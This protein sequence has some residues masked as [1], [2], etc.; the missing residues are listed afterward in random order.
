MS[1]R[2]EADGS[3]L[4]GLLHRRVKVGKL[5]VLQQAQDLYILTPAM[6]GH[7]ALH[8]TAQRGELFGQV[9]ALERRCLIQRIDLPLDQRQVVHRIEDDVFPFPAPRMAGD[10]LAAAADHHLVDITPHPDVLMAVGH[11]D[12]IVVGFVPHERLGRDLNAGLIAGIEWRCR[13]RTHGSQIPLQPIADRLAFAPQSVTLALA[14]LFFKPGVERLPCR[15]LRDRNHEVAP[16]I[17]DE[18]LNVSLVISLSRTAVAIPDEIMGQEAAEQCCPLACPI[19]QDFCDK[20]TIDVIN[21]RLRHGPEERECVDVAVNPGLGHRRRISPHVAAVAMRQVEHEEM[22]LLL[23]AANDHHRLAEIGLP[24]ARWM[25]QWHKHLLAT[26]IPLAH[27]VLEDRIAAGEPAF[28]TKPVEHPLGRM[29]LLARH[30][31]VLI[32]PVIDRRNQRI[33]LGPPDR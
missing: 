13:Q 31:H 19:G 27:I 11:R 16:G 20:A 29:A 5:K 9:P 2:I 1:D 32:K 23:H 25:S 24:M 17:T 10:D 28:V 15:E 21:Y 30:L 4:E 26:L 22:S 12:G 8:Q 14:A 33:Q 6:L 3:E 7:A 18:T